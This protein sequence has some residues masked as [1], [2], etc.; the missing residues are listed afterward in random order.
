MEID[1]QKIEADCNIFLRRMDNFL[2]FH[3]DLE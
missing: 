1:A 3:S 2:S